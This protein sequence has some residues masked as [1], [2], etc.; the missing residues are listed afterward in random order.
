MKER[1]TEDTAWNLVESVPPGL[2]GTTHAY[3]LAVPETPGGTVEVHPSGRWRTRLPVAPAARRIFDLYL[4]LRTRTPYAVGQ[5]GQSLD[6]RIATAEGH[7]HYVTGPEDILRLHRVRA[8]VDAV[9]V[10]AGTVISDDPR[11]TVR[12][13]SGKDPVRVVLDPRGRI[14]PGSRVFD[15]DRGSALLVRA[16]KAEAPTPPR[17]DVLTLRSHPERGFDPEELRSVLAGR[18]LA[19]ILVEGGGITVSRFLQAGALDRL[20]ITVAPILMGSGRPGITLDPI[21]SL[22]EALRPSCRHF[23]LG[24]DLLF[25]LDLSGQ[26]PEEGGPLQEGSP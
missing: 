7:S 2:D 21:A 12:R 26:S 16:P 1:I 11:L 19:R 4:P 15:E 14:D 3:P 5:I 17:V 8:L 24:P 25:D 6:G 23:P 9:V 20:H 22:N 13:T 10:G 18:G